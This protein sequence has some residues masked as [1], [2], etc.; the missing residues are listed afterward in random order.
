LKVNDIEH[1]VRAN[2]RVE[3]SAAPRAAPLVAAAIANAADHTR[4]TTRPAGRRWAA[5]ILVAA[6]ALVAIVSASTFTGHLTNVMQ[7]RNDSRTPLAAH[8]EKTPATYSKDQFLTAGDQLVRASRRGDIPEVLW[9]T[10]RADMTGLEVYVSRSV[11]TKYG[12]AEL[13]ET[14]RAIVGM[15]VTVFRGHVVNDLLPI[16]PTTASSRP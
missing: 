16:R 8:A 6:A 12:P 1:V 10:G 15:P 11:L 4:A 7:P 14:Y 2:L 5:P 13:G 3:A 9:A